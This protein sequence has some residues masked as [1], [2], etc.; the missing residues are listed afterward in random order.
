LF[1]GFFGHPPNLD[2]I[3]L[4]VNEIF[5]LLQKSIPDVK[6]HIVGSNPTDEVYQL[7]N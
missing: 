6:L 5:P 4:F 2:A 3:V 1:I 7:E